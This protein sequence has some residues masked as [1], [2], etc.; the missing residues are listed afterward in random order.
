[1]RASGRAVSLSLAFRPN[2]A[3]RASLPTTFDPTQQIASDRFFRAVPAFNRLAAV[4]DE[5]HRVRR[6]ADR[7]GI[8]E[9]DDVAILGSQFLQCVLARVRG[10]QREADDPAAVLFLS[11]AGEHVVGFDQVNRDRPPGL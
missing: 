9:H 11:E 10:F 1:M 7:A 4:V 8:I 3:G 2:L 6:G 5:F